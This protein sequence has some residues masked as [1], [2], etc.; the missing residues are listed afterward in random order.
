MS[1]VSTGAGSAVTSLAVNTGLTHEMLVGKAFVV[2][3]HDGTR[4][5]CGL[6]A[7][8]GG[9]VA[10]AAGAARLRVRGVLTGL[11]PLASG[12]G[13]HIHV[14][15]TCEVAEPADA[16][17]GHYY[18]GMPTD[19]WLS[20]LGGP[21][22]VADARGVAPIDYSIDGFSLY[23]QNPVHGRAFVVHEANTGTRAGCGVLGAGRAHGR[24]GRTR[25]RRPHT[26]R[27]GPIALAP[28]ALAPFALAPF[29]LAPF[30]M[31][32]FALAPSP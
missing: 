2:H 27:T 22:Y 29:A 23:A 17:G 9:S 31:A 12:G 28:F 16:I 20:S 13:W 24:T 8:G 25:T 11:A 18:E 1:Y 4:I 19:P 10:L 15:H 14:G 26:G 6:L 5:A 7:A 30:A 3:A 32:P 21:T